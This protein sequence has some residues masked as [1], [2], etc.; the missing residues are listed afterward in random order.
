MEELVRTMEQERA[1]LR[2]Y[3]EER[4]LTMSR[5]ETLTTTAAQLEL[6]NKELEIKWQQALERE[7]LLETRIHAAESEAQDWKRR[8]QQTTS[9]MK[10]SRQRDQL[11]K[12]T[13]LEQLRFGLLQAQNELAAFKGIVKKL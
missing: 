8:Q 12:K 5:L 7:K 4:P 1:S 9:L 13:D 6:Q 11:K 10:E 2:E 3:V